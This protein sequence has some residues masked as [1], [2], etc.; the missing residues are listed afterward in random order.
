M[1]M[2]ALAALAPMADAYARMPVADAF[3]WGVCSAAIA[4]GEWYLVAFRSIIRP[5]ADLDCLRRYDDWAH[6]EA[7]DAP[8]F[9]HYFKGPLAEDGSCLSFCLWNSRAEARA[10]A[11]RPAHRDAVTLISQM[12]AAY[13]LEFIR[14]RKRHPRGALEFTPYDAVRPPADR[15]GAVR[16][17]TA[18]AS[19][20]FTPAAT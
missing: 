17:S 6:V 10:S 14:L 7:S 4:P 1:A 9:V 15:S 3:T 16:P 13:T 19:L 11:G 12:Y 2:D 18:P 8:G 20:G 5:D